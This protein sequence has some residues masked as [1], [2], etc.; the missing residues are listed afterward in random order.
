MAQEVRRNIANYK[1]GK[2]IYSIQKI[3]ETHTPTPQSDDAGP[4][5]RHRNAP[6]AWRGGLFS[7]HPY[8]SYSNGPRP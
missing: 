7:S 6:V 8:R 2:G 5:T 1:Q 3:A 4:L